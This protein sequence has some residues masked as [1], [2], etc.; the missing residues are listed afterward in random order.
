MRTW[1]SAVRQENDRLRRRTVV[2]QRLQAGSEVEGLETLV[3]RR[4]LVG[5]PPAMA[6]RPAALAR[7]E[8]RCVDLGAVGARE[9]ETFLVQDVPA[10]PAHAPL[11]LPHPAR[12]ADH[13]QPG[14]LV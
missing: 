11:A 9:E 4:D 13:R 12:L 6:A 8:A 5:G 2:E 10:T 3:R 1:R 7:V 14:L